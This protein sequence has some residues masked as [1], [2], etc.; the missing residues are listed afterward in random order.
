MPI[1]FLR[2]L[3][4]G[5]SEITT[6]TAFCRTA[7]L[8]YIEPVD[9]IDTQPEIKAEAG[10]AVEFTDFNLQLLTDFTPEVV[11]AFTTIDLLPENK[12]KLFN[13]ITGYTE[14]EKKMMTIDGLKM[15]AEKIKTG[16][17][18]PK[19]TRFL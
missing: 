15:L 11:G 6:I 5:S 19:V 12:T 10:N 2:L 9:E 7:H 3:V 18:K 14:E 17:I 16:D 1:R 13:L 4:C 8:E